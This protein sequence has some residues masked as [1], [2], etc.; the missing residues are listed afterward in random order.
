MSYVYVG[1]DDVKLETKSINWCCNIGQVLVFG[2]FAYGFA[3]DSDG[4]GYVGVYVV[5]C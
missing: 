3:C 5:L 1:T 2:N 4:Y